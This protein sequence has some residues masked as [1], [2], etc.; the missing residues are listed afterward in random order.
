MAQPV[1]TSRSDGRYVE[2]TSGLRAG[3]R[4]AAAGSFA[5]KAEQGQGAADH[6]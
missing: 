4:I 5:I 6:H 3:E 2:I 1:A